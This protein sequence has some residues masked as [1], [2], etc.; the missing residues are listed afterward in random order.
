MTTDTVLHGANEKTA[1]DSATQNI[2]L[3]KALRA[4]WH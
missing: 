3:C 1:N 2:Q 4:E